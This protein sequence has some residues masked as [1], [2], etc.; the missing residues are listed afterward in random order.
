LGPPANPGRFTSF[1]RATVLALAEVL[2]AAGLDHPAELRPHHISKR[3]ALGRVETFE[4]IYHFLK[5][6][7]LLS[8]TEDLRFKDT[9]PKA[10][11]NYF[12]A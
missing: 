3:T 4:Q 10:Q 1:H 8:G 6:G 7:E 11:S 12:S 9:W 5:P 2:A